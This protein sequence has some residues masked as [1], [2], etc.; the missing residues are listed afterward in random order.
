MI[1]GFPTLLMQNKRKIGLLIPNVVMKES[2]ADK[3]TTTTHP[4][5]AGATIA[6]HAYLS[7]AELTMDVGF[8]SG[9]SLVDFVDTTAFGV[10]ASLTPTESYQ[11]LRD[12]MNS[13][14]PLTVVTGKRLYSNML[15]T[16]I[17]VTTE[18]ATE[19]VLF[20]SLSMTELLITQTRTLSSA[21]KENMTQGVNTSAVQNNGKKVARPG[22]TAA[23]T[24]SS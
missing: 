14:Q 18:R 4:V 20:A 1:N 3:L 2:H 15:I 17:A 13:R 5:E 23:V 10:Q 9:G 24:G 21:G 16:S 7:P 12:L 19:N 22:P 11:K 6:D 8:S